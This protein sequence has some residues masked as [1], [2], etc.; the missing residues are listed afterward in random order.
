[1][2]YDN[3][4]SSSFSRDCCLL[5]AVKCYS[6][7]FF[8]HSLLTN[9]LDA[10]ILP[11]LWM[12]TESLTGAWWSAAWIPAVQMQSLAS[13]TLRCEAFQ[14][15][16]DFTLCIGIIKDPNRSH[17]IFSSILYPFTSNDVC[18]RVLFSKLPLGTGSRGMRVK[19]KTTQSHPRRVCF[20]RG[21]N[22]RLRG[23]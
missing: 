13:Q 17:R 15:Q 18:I 5:S 3:D 20:G 7:R 21:L 22:Y 19:V 4:M 9:M 16:K 12:K 6:W 14:I 23:S 1:M 11:A 2:L 10:F 8:F